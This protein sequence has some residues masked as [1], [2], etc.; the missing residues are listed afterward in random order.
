MPS[1]NE[2]TNS[3][4][5]LCC[6]ITLLIFLAFIASLLIPRPVSADELTI[7]DLMIYGTSV[8]CIQS[9]EFQSYS[10]S[11]C[12]PY[13]SGYAVSMHHGSSCMVL[14]NNKGEK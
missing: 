14:E 4:I 11:C 12:M 1:K 2:T 8:A 13:K 6:L 7:E 10:D 5:F 9:D 3:V